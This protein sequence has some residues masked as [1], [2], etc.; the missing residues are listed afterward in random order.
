MDRLLNFVPEPHTRLP[1]TP[2]NLL[3]IFL[4]PCVLYYATAILVLIPGDASLYARI[5]LL[6]LT[7][8]SAFRAST[9]LDFASWFADPLRFVYLNH[10]L[11]LVTSTLA[12]RAL[13]W[14]FQTEPYYRL[15]RR[16]TIVRDDGETTSGTPSPSSTPRDHKVPQLAEL[17]SPATLARLLMDAFDLMFNLR[18]LNWNWSDRLYVPP[19]TRPLDSRPR[20]LAATALSFLKALAIFDGAH[21]VLQLLSPH[22]PGCDFASPR[23][24]TIF[25]TAL[26]PALRYAKSSA[27]TFVAGV[28][29]IAGITMGYQG[30]TLLGVGLAGN[31]PRAWPPAFAAPW[32]A[33]S[34][35]EFWSKRWH[36][37]FR[38][39]F[40]GA[41]SLPFSYLLGKPGVALGA[42]FVSGVLH[43]WGLWGMGRGTEFRSVAGYFIM[44]G[45]GILVEHKYRALT[46]HRVGAHES[47]P[48]R[49]NNWLGGWRGRAWTMLWVVGWG[50]F[51][52]DAWFRK[53]LAGSQFFVEGTR[54]TDVLYFLASLVRSALRL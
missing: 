27:V 6:P 41:G 53:G 12:L 23:G 36:Q 42:F 49:G 38:D 45:F 37:S 1:I 26:P 25:D 8:W 47:A 31:D 30:F 13:V 48:G 2:E 19:D 40:I 46:G 28:A 51:L 7:L 21:R 33:P 50:N 52:V 5:A 14:T 10:G 3:S 43:V 22:T 18:G 24:G 16:L 44:M 29:V 54:P 32:H 9:K 4:P 39:I 15:P 17:E 34:L 11:L 35:T 20:F